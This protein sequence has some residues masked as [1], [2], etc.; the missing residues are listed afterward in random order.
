VDETIWNMGTGDYGA[1]RTALREGK[2]VAEAAQSAG[3]QL[4]VVHRKIS[5]Y[6]RKLEAALSGSNATIDVREAIDKPLEQ[7]ILEI[8]SKES[9][10]E[11]E[12][13]AAIQ[14]LGILEAWVK[15]GL[16]GDMSPLEANRIILE[17]GGRLNWGSNRG[18]GAAV[19]EELRPAYRALFGSLKSAIYNAVPD[20]QNLHERLINLYA[21]KSDLENMP[22]MKELNPVTA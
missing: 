2:S 11:P 3:G 5:D 22:M 19:S 1:Y 18:A 15:H 12:K 8:I 16:D 7:N 4:A 10:G 6:T 20:T 14:Q 9:I 17:I 21:V 13:D